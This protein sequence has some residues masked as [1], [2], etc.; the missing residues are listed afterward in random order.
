MCKPY[1]TF[2]PEIQDVCNLKN[3]KKKKIAAYVERKVSFVQVVK[4]QNIPEQ[5]SCNKY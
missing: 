4:I 1:I 2:K 3:V 5:I